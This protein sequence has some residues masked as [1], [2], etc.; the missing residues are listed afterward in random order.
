[1]R[2]DE[3]SLSG[4]CD[5]QFNASHF[6]KHNFHVKTQLCHPL[7]MHTIKRE[8]KCEWQQFTAKKGWTTTTTTNEYK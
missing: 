1:M 7:K 5:F 8:I 3:Y 4:I 2:M 6:M